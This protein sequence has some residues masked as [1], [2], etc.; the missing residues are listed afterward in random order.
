MG[1]VTS[2]PAGYTLETILSVS[3]EGGVNKPMEDWGSVLLAKYGKQRYAYRRDLAV[4]RLGFSTD[5][6]AFYCEY[7]GVFLDQYPCLMAHD[8]VCPSQCNG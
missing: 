5:N 6:G 4:Q 2:I 8:C 7:S 1:A 3:A